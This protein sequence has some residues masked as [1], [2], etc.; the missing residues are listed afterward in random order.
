M[1]DEPFDRWLGNLQASLRGA[2]REWL[3]EAEERLARRSPR[4]AELLAPLSDLCLR[5]GKRLRPA[6]AAA[7]FEACGGDSRR[8]EPLLRLGIALEL[9][10]GY[11][12]AHDDWMDGD[13]TRRGGP[14]VHAAFRHVTGSEHLGDALAVVCG[15]LG[16]LLA[17]RAFGEVHFPERCA[18]TALSTWLDLQEEVLLGQQL[19]LLDHPH[20]SLVHRLKTGSYSVR[21][22]LRL[23]A[24]LADA[25]EAP[26]E[27]LDRFAEPL[28]EAFQLRDDLLGTFGN[29]ARTGK[30]VGAD[31][32]SGK[33]T[34]LIEEAERL[35]PEEDKPLL[36]RVLGDPEASEA[37]LEDAM[38]MLERSGVREAVRE[39]AEQRLLRALREL[40][41]APLHPEGRTRLRTLAER[42]VRRDH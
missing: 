28:G 3:R 10:Q 35:L 34:A 22:P 23:G 33:R 2:L 19:D 5:G 40:E 13:C 25:E 7:A 42:I 15:D 31:L 26:L 14:S 17:W 20:T 11:L 27:A 16:A 37:D 8:T 39:R 41:Q 12:L 18:E 6:L 30:P 1:Q 4:G 24:L 36:W 38:T 21:G 9:L 32:R 29:P